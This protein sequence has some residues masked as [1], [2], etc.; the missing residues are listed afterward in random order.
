MSAY[1]GQLPINGMMYNGRE[2]SAMYNG[3]MIWPTATVLVPIPWSASGNLTTIGRYGG[4]DALTGTIV[5]LSETPVDFLMTE[6][7]DSFDCTAKDATTRAN[8]S[9]GSGTVMQSGYKHSSLNFYYSATVAGGMATGNTGWLWKPSSG[10]ITDLDQATDGWSSNV[11]DYGSFFFLNGC[12]GNQTINVEYK[13]SA[14]SGRF[15]GPKTATQY[16]VNMLTIT[17]YMPYPYVSTVKSGRNTLSYT[18]F[19]SASGVYIPE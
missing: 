8:P 17:A 11:T 9:V 16:P 19:W 2:C 18:S 13:L 14:A 6:S 4:L 7:P 5:S 15:H 10:F 12:A 3:N 1:F